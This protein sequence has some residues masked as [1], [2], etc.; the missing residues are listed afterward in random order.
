MATSDFTPKSTPTVERPS[1]EGIPKYPA[2]PIASYQR[3]MPPRSDININNLGNFLDG[4]SD[5]FENMGQFAEAVQADLLRKLLAK[6]MPKT[7]GISSVTGK[8]GGLSSLYSSE[9]RPYTLI[10]TATGA[11][12][13]VYIGQFG[14]DLYASWRTFLKP[15][16]NMDTLK[17]IAIIAVGIA[18][19]LSMIL[20]VL[21]IWINAQLSYHL[22][23]FAVTLSSTST[24]FTYDPTQPI[25]VNVG[26]VGLALGCFPISFGTSLILETALLLAAGMFFKKQLL[27]FFQTEPS[28]FDTEDIT[29]MTLTVHKAVVDA[30][31]ACGIREDVVRAKSTLKGGRSDANL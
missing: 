14:S 11:N 3:Y 21:G 2:P 17:T 18:G 8:K 20:F 30:L 26:L 25:E 6:N 23:N 28:W 15:K 31:L 16:L 7:V 24:G 9:S 22:N 29:A 19:I 1:N 10:K 4:W 12:V 13:T 5:T 27:Y